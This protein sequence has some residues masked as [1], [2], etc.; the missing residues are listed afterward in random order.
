MGMMILI[1]LGRLRRAGNFIVNVILWMLLLTS[2][3][4]GF[5]DKLL[6]LYFAHTEISLAQNS[7]FH[8][9]ISKGLVDYD[10]VALLDISF[11]MWTK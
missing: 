6:I 11:F 4:L 1:D 7:A 2:F 3:K 8:N 5:S 10:F 9:C